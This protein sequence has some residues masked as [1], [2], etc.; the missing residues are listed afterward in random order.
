MFRG[1]KRSTL[2]PVFSSH[3][4]QGWWG[5]RAESLTRTLYSKMNANLGS[6]NASGTSAS[7][8]SLWPSHFP[9]CCPPT[10]AHDLGGTVFLLV[11]TD[12]PT[13]LDFECAKE[14]GTFKGKDECRR[15]SLSCGVTLEYITEL[16]DSSPR[17]KCHLIASAKLSASDGKIKQVGSP[18]HHSMWLRQASL[19]TGTALFQVT[20]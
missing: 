8:V 13:A 6:S 15:A 11:A 12:P 16:R 1:L 3:S 17:L 20:A 10:D 9:A 4:A 2:T 18:G 14:R 5:I 7:G 19:Q